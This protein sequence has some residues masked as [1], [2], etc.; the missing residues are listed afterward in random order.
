MQPLYVRTW[1]SNLQSERQDWKV[2]G[3]SSRDDCRCWRMRGLDLDEL[4]IRSC[5]FA[6]MRL[7]NRESGSRT[8]DELSGSLE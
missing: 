3:M 4:L 1:S 8:V 2:A 7:T 5:N 6:S